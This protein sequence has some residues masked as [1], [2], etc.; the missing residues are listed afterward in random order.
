M[1]PETR[2]ELRA[3]AVAVDAAGAA[4]EAAG[5]WCAPRGNDAAEDARQAWGEASATL[6]EALTPG[7]VKALLDASEPVAGGEFEARLRSAY[8]E[9][10][11]LAI[12]SYDHEEVIASGNS[13][14][15]GVRGGLRIPHATA[16]RKR[17][18]ACVNA[19]A[20]IADPAYFIA[21]LSAAHARLQ[22][23][24]D[25]AVAEAGRLREA[26]QFYAAPT[27][28]M[29]ELRFLA[30]G[31]RD[32]RAWSKTPVLVDDGNRARAALAGRA[33]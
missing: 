26:L 2:A 21:T 23:E 15:G 7:V 19:C 24:R 17:I 30:C 9:P 1:T 32:A 10:W 25:A 8:G 18:V 4:V 31:C 5:G 33:P 14:I 3:K 12:R 22:A 16:L 11:S 13:V 29:S 6:K 27:A 20:G 28:Y